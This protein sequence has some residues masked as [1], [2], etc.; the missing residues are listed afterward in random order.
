METIQV[1]PWIV[2]YDAEAT[3]A[4]Y[5]QIENGDAD[6]C[7]CGPCRNFVQVR[8]KIY[9]EQAL[10]VFDRLGID[11]RKEAKLSHVCRESPGWHFY[12]GSFYFFGIIEEIIEHP[13]PIREDGKKADFAPVA[14]HFQWFISRPD[15]LH[16]EDVAKVF[17]GQPLVEID[18][19]HFKVPW[20]LEVKEPEIDVK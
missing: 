15:F 5:G 1:G 19:A 13:K 11:Y 4:A 9:P 2:K 17:G 8:E 14:E 16:G 12:N 3:R 6:K 20:V 10:R 18:F 7:S